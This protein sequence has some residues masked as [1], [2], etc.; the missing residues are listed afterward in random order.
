MTNLISRVLPCAFGIMAGVAAAAEWSEEMEERLQ[1]VLD[2]VQV[3]S[4]KSQLDGDD[5]HLLGIED[6]RFVE[7]VAD[8]SDYVAESVSA[9]ESKYNIVAS[10]QEVRDSRVYTEIDT[11]QPVKGVLILIYRFLASS[12]KAYIKFLFDSNERIG[13]DQQ[14]YLATKYRLVELKRTLLK[15]ITCHSEN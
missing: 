2:P 10:K 12:D 1:A 14:Q 4:A 5:K 11:V 7:A 13:T 6:T 8:C 3:A 9:W 15:N